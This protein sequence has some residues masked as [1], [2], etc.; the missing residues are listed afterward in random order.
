VY[1]SNISRRPQGERAWY[2]QT[3]RANKCSSFFRLGAFD[4]PRLN[5][6]R[7]NVGL[8][9]DVTFNQSEGDM[10]RG[11]GVHR[12]V[13]RMAETGACDT[14]LPGTDYGQVLEELLDALPLIEISDKDYRS[15]C[16]PCHALEEMGDCQS[17]S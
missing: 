1:L 15:F 4:V 13:A 11:A 12:S 5:D 3:T 16:W 2:T 6:R 10:G 14:G 17:G 8:S 7:Q 9:T